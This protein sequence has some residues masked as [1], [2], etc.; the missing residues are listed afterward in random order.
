MRHFGV[1]SCERLQ[2]PQ[3]HTHGDLEAGWSVLGSN[4]PRGGGGGV[5]N[6]SKKEDEN[7]KLDYFITL[8]SQES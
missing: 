1:F 6:G 4:Q 3:K 7:G 2:R 5:K 8:L